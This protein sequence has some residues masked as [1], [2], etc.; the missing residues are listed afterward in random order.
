MGFGLVLFAAPYAWSPPFLFLKAHY[1]VY[2][3]GGS[4]GSRVHIFQYNNRQGDRPTYA[5]LILPEKVFAVEP[6]LSSYAGRPAMAATSILPL[7]EFAYQHVPRQ[8]WATT[9]IHL[10][11]TAGLRLLSSKDA[12]DILDSC[13]QV[14]AA[15]PFL[16]KP[17]WARVLS[18]DTEGLFA[19]AA[20]NYASGALEA[21]GCCYKNGVLFKD[22]WKQ[23][24]WVPSCTLIA[25]QRTVQWSLRPAC[26][27]TLPGVQEAAY[28]QHHSRKEMVHSPNLFHGV[29]ELGGASFQVTFVPHQR[30]LHVQRSGL[31]V[32]LPGV[33]ARLFTHSYLGLG[34]DSALQQA[35]AEVHRQHQAAAAQEEGREQSVLDPCLPTG[36]QASDGRL[37]NASYASCLAIVQRVLPHRLCAT[38]APGHHPHHYPGQE[39]GREEPDGNEDRDAPAGLLQHTL[40]RLAAGASQDLQCS[41]GGVHLPPVT[42]TQFLAIE[43]LYWTARALGLGPDASLH[44]LQAAGQQYCAKPWEELHT[45]FAGHVPDQFITRYCFGAAYVYALL[46][47]RL[48]LP[49]HE[50]GVLQF[51]NTVK[52]RH[53]RKQHGQQHDDTQSSHTRPEGLW[54]ESGQASRQLGSAVDEPEGQLGDTVGEVDVGLSWVLG[55]MVMQSMSG[56]YP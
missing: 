27:L 22:A 48:G 13:S 45:T 20:A 7:L 36:Y 37:G 46:H 30:D 5:Q 35:V 28:H 24:G 40:H 6:G 2:L 15:S 8:A 38:A 23:P 52:R 49:L 32:R 55:A 25:Q 53:G 26:A 39:A 54:Q 4:S 19:W 17:G 12:E 31:L 51:T 44:E 34:M 9:P 33:H 50:R 29:L 16:F 43:N 18:G 42:G 1:S 10:L 47:E 41:L 11:A 3:D 14:L 56:S 21:R